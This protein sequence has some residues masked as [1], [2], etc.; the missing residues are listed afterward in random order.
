M[1]DLEGI[2]NKLDSINDSVRSLADRV[3]NIELENQSSRSRSN[4]NT[5]EHNG[6]PDNT[7]SDAGVTPADLAQLLAT[8]PYDNMVGASNGADIQREF[9]H[10]RDSLARVSIPKKYKVN[11]LT[12]GIGKDS[13]A[14]LGVV[15]K[16]AWYAETDLKAI[17]SLQP[18][19]E[20]EQTIT[21]QKDEI[22]KLFTIF[23]VQVN[24]L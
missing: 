20:D 10:V 4:Q 12:K 15:S 19:R 3:S 7:A 11:D 24:F 23:S 22:K 9:D 8:S 14:T 17:A 1:S 21:L 5:T 13:K 18:E 2:L 6:G 16:C